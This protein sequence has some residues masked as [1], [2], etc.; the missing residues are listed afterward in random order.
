MADRLN[1][2]DEM[3]CAA[4][5]DLG[6]TRVVQVLWRFAEPVPTAALRAEWTRLNG[7]PLSR[8]AVRPLVPGA[9]R[10][11]ARADNGEPLRE[12][13]TALTDAIGWIDEQAREPLPA[14]SDLLWRLAA[15]PYRQGTLVSLT[16]PHFRADGL[17]V[18]GA[19][20]RREVANAGPVPPAGLVA[21]DVADA[22]GQVAGAL[23]GSVSLL[24]APAARSRAR[25]AVAR[26]PSPVTGSS[27]RWFASTAFDL[28]A[29]EW[30]Q[31]AKERGGTVNSLFVEIAANLVRA[32][33]P[34]DEI[35]VGIP[36]SLRLG[37]HDGRANALIVVP[38]AVLAGRPRHND[39]GRTRR[40]TK[41]ALTAP[42]PATLVAEPLW[43]L[44]PKRYAS[45]LKAP[46][47]QQTDVVASN[48]G[49]V[50]D[51][52]AVFAGQRAESVA[53]RTMNVPG[54]V[55]EKA[56]LR[57]S[58]CLLRD[59]DRLTVTVTG[60]PDHF[61]AASSLRTLVADEF[62]AWGLTTARQWF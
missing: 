23:V 7:G 32:R 29:T 47:A 56:R 49:D 41:A 45:R 33:V 27:P 12:C 53:L 26:M 50:P 8:R 35:H 42:G 19:L 22:I 10:R 51:R 59:G 48:F 21:A 18:F 17:G 61:G 44:L 11:W 34:L 16:V 62:A 38:L 31:C 58:L 36:K 6:S 3:L 43:H 39:L 57:A 52:V 30:E 13:S 46:G 40:D 9:R 37:A 24:A 5:V 60:M 20:E 14:T 25:A 28:D 1:P 2:T 55:P 15:A 54:L 4:G